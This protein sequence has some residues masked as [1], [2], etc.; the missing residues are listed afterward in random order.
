[1]RAFTVL[2]LLVLAGCASR[3]AG[4]NRD[5]DAPGAKSSYGLPTSPHT[6]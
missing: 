4:E 6:F 3:G 5:Y 1:M 2:L